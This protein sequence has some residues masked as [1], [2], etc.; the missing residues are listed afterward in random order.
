VADVNLFGAIPLAIFLIIAVAVG[1]RLLLLARRTHELPELAIGAGLL[2]IALV[3]FPIEIVGRV[4]PHAGTD[5]GSVLFAI[6]FLASSA[7]VALFFVFTWKVFRPASRLAAGAATGAGVALLVNWVGLVHAEF[8]GGTLAEIL[9]RTRPWAIGEV[10]ALMAAFAWS[11]AES[12]HYYGMLR[13]RLALGLVDPVIVNRFLLWG[14]SGCLLPVLSLAI[15]FFLLAGMVVMRDPI[16]LATIA[17]IGTAM[18]ATWLLTF[19]PP[20]RYQRF[21]RERARPEPAPA[22]AR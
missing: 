20:D 19:L 17:V 2:L 5:L 13:R 21:L 14:I 1:I 10:V 12:L 9:P 15:V 16:P 3:G 18:S 7:G 8:Q 11:G 6:G 22:S 4:P